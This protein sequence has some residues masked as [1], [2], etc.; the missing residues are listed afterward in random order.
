MKVCMPYTIVY[1]I[2]WGMGNLPNYS[3]RWRRYTTGTSCQR[4]VTSHAFIISS[5]C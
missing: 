4:P 5:I 2:E 3:F 1:N